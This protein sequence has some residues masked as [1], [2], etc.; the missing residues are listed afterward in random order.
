LHGDGVFE[1]IVPPVTVPGGK[2]VTAVP[3]LTPRSPVTAVKPVLV[4]VVP[5][6]TAK[7][8]AVPRGGACADAC[9]GAKRSM[10]TA[11]TRRLEYVRF[12][13]NPSKAAGHLNWLPGN[14]AEA[15]VI[16][17]GQA[18]IQVSHTG[19]EGRRGSP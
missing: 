12:M 16:A 3:G 4:T 10:T 2:P 17:R 8:A 9:E 15:S 5:A 11:L 18:Y 1:W 19:R 14:G 7:L 6:R 13:A